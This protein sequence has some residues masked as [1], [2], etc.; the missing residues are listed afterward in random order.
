[1]TT[2]K[3]GDLIARAKRGVH[4]W[5][6][7]AMR[8]FTEDLLA[9]MAK[10]DMNNAALAAAAD[11]SP[12]YI[13]KVFRGSE[14]FTL[15]TMSKL[16]LAVGCHVRV[17]LAP[18][19]REEIKINVPTGNTVT[20]VASGSAPHIRLVASEGITIDAKAA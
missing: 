15:E 4:Y 9:R 14:N 5:T 18:N 3:Y 16:A 7:I 10:R 11:V 19:T 1:M 20:Q 13:T 2:K 12:A 17:Q 8:N 6:R